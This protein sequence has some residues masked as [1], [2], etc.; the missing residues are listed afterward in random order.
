MGLVVNKFER[1]R[2]MSRSQFKA[3]QIE[4][5]ELAEFLALQLGVSFTVV[6]LWKGSK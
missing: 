2:I 6:Q 3:L 5:A 1:S 4:S